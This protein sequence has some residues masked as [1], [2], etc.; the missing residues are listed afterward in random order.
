MDWK[1]GALWV[2]PMGPRKD[3]QRADPWDALKG[4]LWDSLQAAPLEI[5]RARQRVEQRDGRAANQTVEKKAVQTES[6]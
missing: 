1:W 5:Q 6:Q 3:T 4:N 2:E